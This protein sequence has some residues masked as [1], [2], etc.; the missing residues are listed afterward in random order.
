[1]ILNKQL[2]QFLEANCGTTYVR[3]KN[4]PTCCPS[5]KTLC[6]WI[7]AVGG[8]KSATVHPSL[9]A[10]EGCPLSPLLFCINLNDIDSVADGAQ[11][12]LIGS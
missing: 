6:W 5:S 4:P 9:G 8:D 7:H 10:K 1:V 11:G 12:A 3:T 2:T